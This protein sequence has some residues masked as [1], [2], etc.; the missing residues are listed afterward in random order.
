MQM[1]LHFPP[2]WLP[3]TLAGWVEGSP[4]PLDFRRGKK[5]W[6]AAMAIMLGAASS[7][8][9]SLLLLLPLVGKSEPEPENV[10]QGLCQVE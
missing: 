4:G 10:I 1:I 7:A 2:V 6:C 5:A 3:L 8:F 9:S